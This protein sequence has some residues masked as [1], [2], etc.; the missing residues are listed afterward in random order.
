V[1]ELVAYRQ[2][3]ISALENVVPELSKT[4]AAIPSKEW[5]IKN[6]TGTHTSHYSLAHLCEFEAQAFSTLLRRIESG[7]APLLPLFDDHDWTE[8]LY[9]PA[10]PVQVILEEFTCALTQE[11]IWLRALPQDSWSLTARHPWW[12]VHTFQ[13]WVELQLAY[14]HKHLID[15]AALAT[16]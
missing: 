8:S 11:V 15:L 3:L 6:K 16:I 9:K 13:W 5:Q 10:K 4:V 2:G 14:F 12:G 7:G 1:D